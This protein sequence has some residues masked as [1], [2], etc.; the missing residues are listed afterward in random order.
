MQPFSDKIKNPYTA[1]LQQQ[2]LPHDQ[3]KASLKWLQL[4]K[5]ELMRLTAMST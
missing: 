5:P 2:R 1:F 4:S 3:I